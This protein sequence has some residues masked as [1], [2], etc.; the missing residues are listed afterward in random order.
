LESKLKAT[1]VSN[2]HAA[3]KGKEKER[4]SVL[5]TIMSEIQMFEI[6]TKNIPTEE[7]IIAIL[8][9]MSKQRGDSIEAFTKA[10]RMDLVEI[11]EKECLIIKEFLPK[12]LSDKEILSFIK[13]AIESSNATTI[14]DMGAV[15]NI[16]KPKCNGR[17]NIKTVSSM[18]RDYLSSL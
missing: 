11:E 6:D 4:L 3:M 12:Q 2:V 7:D 14:K 17:A 13:E 10:K 9:K 16:L 15:M 8:S 5:R 1:L 18:V